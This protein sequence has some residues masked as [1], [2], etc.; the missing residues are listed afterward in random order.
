MT[1]D[2]TPARVGFQYTVL[3]CVPRADREEFV[4]VGVVLYSQGAEYLCAVTHLD[5]TRLL[6]LSPDIDLVGVRDSLDAIE[7]LCCGSSVLTQALQALGPR[8]GW[9]SAPRSTVVRPGPIH[10]G[11]TDDPARQLEHLLETLVR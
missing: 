5:E 4:N 11:I 9:L 7:A 10:G 8:F 6:A 2:R 1:S 3:R